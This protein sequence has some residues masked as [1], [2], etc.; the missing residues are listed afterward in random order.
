MHPPKWK[1]VIRT[2]NFHRRTSRNSEGLVLTSVLRQ[3]A[4]NPTA[5]TIVNNAKRKTT[6]HTLHVD[7]SN[8]PM[9]GLKVEGKQQ[10]LT[11]QP[12]TVDKDQDRRNFRQTR[13]YTTK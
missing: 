4:T 11:Q 5:K 9:V 7:D 1:H 8:S 12:H 6:K 3:G 2:E 10:A 13:L